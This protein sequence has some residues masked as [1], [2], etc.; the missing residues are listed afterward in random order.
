MPRV[1]VKVTVG[2]SV[3]VDVG[4]SVN[5][6]VGTNVSVSA[7][8][9]VAARA[10]EAKKI[11]NINQSLMKVFNFCSHMQRSAQRQAL[12]AWWENQSL[13]RKARS[14]GLLHFCTA[15]HPVRYTLC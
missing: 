4:M 1:G 6:G 9:T 15:H 14:L 5:V 12:P 13:K 11:E 2:M 3:F 7:G 8:A 10:Q